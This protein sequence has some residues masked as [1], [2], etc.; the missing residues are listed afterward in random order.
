MKR[1][2]IRRLISAVYFASITILLQLLS[3][4]AVVFCAKQV[5]MGLLISIFVLTMA[6]TLSF[7]VAIYYDVI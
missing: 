3:I 2:K 7:V 6:L 1:E 4:C 5:Y